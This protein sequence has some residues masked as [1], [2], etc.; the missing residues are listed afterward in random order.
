MK[1]KCAV[2]EYFVSGLGSEEH[3]VFTGL[4]EGSEF[5]FGNGSNNNVKIEGIDDDS[6]ILVFDCLAKVIPS[7][8]EYVDVVEEKMDLNMKIP[9]RVYRMKIN[10]NEEISLVLPI[11]PSPSYI[12]KIT[13]IYEEDI[14]YYE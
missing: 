14:V 3:T 8:G 12:M 9:N 11:T 7:N 13:A 6:C 4:H 2:I 1:R 10:V 5:Y